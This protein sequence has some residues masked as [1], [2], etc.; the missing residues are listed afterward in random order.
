MD[1]AKRIK[2]DQ[3]AYEATKGEDVDL[4]ALVDYPS[5]QFIFGVPS[6][7]SPRHKEEVGFIEY[8]DHRTGKRTGLYLDVQECLDFQMGMDRIIK[9]SKENSKELWSK[10][11]KEWSKKQI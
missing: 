2:P 1:D 4:I 11:E 8:I 7:E 5:Y 9:A 10:H 6:K 3:G